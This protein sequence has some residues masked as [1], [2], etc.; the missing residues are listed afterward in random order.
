VGYLTLNIKALLSLE[1]S[2]AT[3]PATRRHIPKDVNSSNT[4]VRTSNV[5]SVRAVVPVAVSVLKMR[6]VALK[7]S[8]DERSFVRSFFRSFV[9]SFVRSF[10]HSFIHSFH[11]F[12][13]SFR[14]MPYDR[15]RA[16]SKASS[17]QSA[18]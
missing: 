14:S 17:S 16:S 8:K 4:A 13:H 5:A 15:S 18:I 7:S 1:T 6:S 11:S 12:I 3:R 9:S 2:E 10:I